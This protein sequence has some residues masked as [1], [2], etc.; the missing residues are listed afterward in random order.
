MMKA[1]L[2][3]SLSALDEFGE[4]HPACA[5][6]HLLAQLH[7]IG[8]I[9]AVFGVNAAH[10]RAKYIQRVDGIAFPVQDQVGWIQVD[11]RF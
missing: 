8:G 9:E 5:D 1:P 4:A 2:Y 6:L 7:R 11:P 3:R 10:P